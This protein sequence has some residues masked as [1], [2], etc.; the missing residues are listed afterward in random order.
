MAF[1]SIRRSFAK[2]GPLQ[3]ASR[4]LEESEI[5]RLEA[6]V[7]LEYYTAIEQMYRDRIS[8]LKKDIQLITDERSSATDT[9]K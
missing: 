6:M 8:R 2:P 3:I 1:E 7:K 4:M 9:S 5:Q